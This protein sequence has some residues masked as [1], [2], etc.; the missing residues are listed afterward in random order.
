MNRMQ[1]KT[2]LQS[3]LCN[4]MWVY[5]SHGADDSFALG[6]RIGRHL[7]LGSVVALYGDL[8][9]G[10]TLL[11]KGIASAATGLDP[12]RVSSP[13]FVH[14]HLYPVT[15]SFAHFD[16]Y[17]LQNESAFL[18]M[19]FDEYLF[20]EGVCCI[21]WPECIQHLLPPHTWHIHLVHKQGDLRAIQMPLE[22]AARLWS[23]PEKGRIS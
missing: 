8:G 10:K 17:R 7:P 19:G 14:L 5:P 18:N 20:T 16:L 22:Q 11:I 12:S 6:Q 15:P 23:L 2:S 1:V 3:S 9:A 4:R 21:E 13:T